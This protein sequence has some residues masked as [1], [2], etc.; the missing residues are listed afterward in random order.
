MSDVEPVS[1]TL[2]D[3]SQ[4]VWA[5]GKAQQEARR[6]GIPMWVSSRRGILWMCSQRPTENEETVAHCYPGGRIELYRKG[7]EG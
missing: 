7:G 4:L 5:L 2:D 1:I 6:T 3:P